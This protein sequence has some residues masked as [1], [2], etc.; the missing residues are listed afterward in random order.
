[1]ANTSETAGFLTPSTFPL[2]DN[3]L[4]IFFQEWIVG[5]TAFA[6]P[7]YVFPRWQTEP[8]NI[9]PQNVDWMAIG[10]TK[11]DPD[12][13]AAELHIQSQSGYNQLRR[14]EEIDFLVSAYGPNARSLLQM[15]RDGMQISQNREILSLNSMALKES[16]SIISF[17]ELLKQVWY[18]RSDFSFTIKRQIVRD[19]Q[20]KNLASSHGLLN[21]ERYIEPIDVEERT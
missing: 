9:P 7:S 12:T 8:P 19:Y 17:P 18:N 15:L 4:V 14:H 20:V 6:T 3:A 11:S 21:N 5:L 2:E 1:M 13:F 16:G 10:I